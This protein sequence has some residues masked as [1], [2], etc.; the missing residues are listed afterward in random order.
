VPENKT[1]QT[2]VAKAFAENVLIVESYPFN[3]QWRPTGL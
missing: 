3:R 2:G 1:R